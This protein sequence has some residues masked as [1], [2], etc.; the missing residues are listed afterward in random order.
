MTSVELREVTPEVLAELRTHVVLPAEQAEWVGG[1][2]DDVLE[3][4]AEFPEG[5][6]WPRAVYA[7]G[8]PVG[9]M[10]L[11]WDA[12]PRPP[13]IIGPWFLWKLMVAPAAQGRGIGREV[14]RLAASIVK[15]QG[16]TELL[17][18]C[19]H[20]P[21]SPSDFYLGLGFVRT[22]EYAEHDE[23]VLALAL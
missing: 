13:E 12:V 9:F 14:V 17:T 10:M 18:S 2:V 21:G 16:A 15:E 7:D 4:A 22:G 23:E 20:G 19:A 3:E 1:T 11:S 5:K 8:R 6:P